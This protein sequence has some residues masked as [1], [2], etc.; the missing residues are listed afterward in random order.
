MVI[1]NAHSKAS[2]VTR[3][4]WAVLGQATAHPSE[5]THF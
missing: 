3:L 1:G 2:P 4:H 5:M